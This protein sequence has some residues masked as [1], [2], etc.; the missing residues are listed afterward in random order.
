MPKIQQ[1]SPSEELAESQKAD[2]KLL[3]AD[4]TQ[5]FPVK[6]T[7]DLCGLK[8]GDRIVRKYAGRG[9]WICECKCG[10]VRVLTGYDLRNSRSKQCM[11]CRSVEH[12]HGHNTSNSNTY[13]SWAHMIE[14]CGPNASPKDYPYYA[15][16]GITVCERWKDFKQ[17]L[18]DMGECPVGKSIDRWPNRRGNYEPGNVRWATIIQQAQNTSANVFVLL[19]G[20]KMVLIEAAR[21]IG[22]ARCPLG[23]NIKKLNLLPNQ[24]A[25]IVSW[26]RPRFRTRVKLRPVQA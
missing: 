13:R 5:S 10:D 19:N 23:K 25:E 3:L 2:A 1:Q 21:R 18:A 8:F 12:F 14:R 24:I 20:E 26:N 6:R 15:G 11:K 22:M 16:I 7:K 9:K 17:F 4:E